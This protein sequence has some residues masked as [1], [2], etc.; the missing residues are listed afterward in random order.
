MK[1][2]LL[3]MSFFCASLSAA[4]VDL[5]Q[6]VNLGG[7]HGM[8]VTAKKEI[9]LADTF[10]SRRTVKSQ[11]Y[12]IKQQ[13]VES[14]SVS[15]AG[16]AG[17]SRNNLG[18]LICDLHGS[19]VQQVDDHFLPL[20]SWKIQNPWI[21]RTDSL[22]NTFALTYG[23]EL[24]K[25][26]PDGQ[27]ETLLTGLDAPFDFAFT[28]NANEMWISEQGENLG[29]VALWD[30][31]PGQSAQTKLTARYHWSNP[32]GLLFANGLL[33]VL[34]TELGHLVKVHADGSTELTMADLGIPILI[35]PWGEQLLIYSNQ[36][37]GSP[38]LLIISK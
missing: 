30:L 19:K 32:E 9:L 20:Q 5:V 8:E 27:T 18:Y 28:D 11:L 14:I 7:A 21:A 1:K 12:R 36:Y 3:A 31:T 6:A 34:D 2:M 17:L 13:T 33:W 26:L 25:L 38:A 10:R 37:Q 22:G 24:L 35:R 16:L 23:G 29:R 15:G 4:T